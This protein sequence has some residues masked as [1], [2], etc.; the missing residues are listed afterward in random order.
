M[1]SSITDV[2]SKLLEEGEEVVIHGGERSHLTSFLST[3]YKTDFTSIESALKIGYA[4]SYPLILENSVFIRF[5]KD[6]G[7]I[8]VLPYFKDVISEDNTRTSFIPSSSSD[9]YNR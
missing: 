6:E 2:N 3:D 7:E 4:S 9:G 5:V 8:T 1:T